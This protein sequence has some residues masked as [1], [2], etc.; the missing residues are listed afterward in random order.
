MLPGRISLA[1]IGDDPLLSSLE[2][3]LRNL[4]AG[5]ERL[6]R[7]CHLAARSRDLELELS[8]RIREH[9]EAALGAG[10]VDS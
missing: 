6:A 3:L 7:Q 1:Q 8:F 5:R 10:R 2:H 9:D 4:L